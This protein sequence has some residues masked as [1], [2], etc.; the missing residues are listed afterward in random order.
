[1]NKLTTITI[2]SIF[3]FVLYFSFL[4]M[5][6]TEYKHDLN[7]LNH[8][9]DTILNNTLKQQI[10]IDSINTNMQR[11]KIELA[12]ISTERKMI[13]LENK[14]KYARNMQQINNYK[15]ILDSIQN[16]R[17]KLIEIAKNFVP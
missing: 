8:Q 10:I 1:M 4:T 17:N 2:V 13:V 14:K 9:I 7:N 16:E 15:N 12:I 6:V 3:L 11:A 5:K